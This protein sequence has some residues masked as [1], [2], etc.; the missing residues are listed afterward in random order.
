M[1]R[2]LLAGTAT[3]GGLLL[4][5][6]SS[7]GDPGALRAWR[8]A[9]PVLSVF[10]AR[11][12]PAASRSVEEPQQAVAVAAALQ[13][14][15][16]ALQ[17]DIRRLQ[18]Q[19]AD[20]MQ[21]VAGLQA[22]ADQAKRE[23]EQARVNQAAAGQAAPIGLGQAQDVPGDAERT[24]GPTATV[25]RDADQSDAS[26][27]PPAKRPADVDRQTASRRFE[28]AQPARSAEPP[29]Q[30]EVQDP[31]PVVAPVPVG[32]APHG[33]APPP[34][35]RADV[36]QRHAAR[37]AA[38][39]IRDRSAAAAASAAANGALQDSV[40]S[41]S[42]AFA[43]N[44]GQTQPGLDRLSRPPETPSS[45]EPPTAAALAT[46]PPVPAGF[47][48]PRRVTPRDRLAKARSAIAAGR[49]A[50]A[51]QLL[52]EAQLQLVFRP[53]TAGG[54][55]PSTGSRSAGQVADAL[56]MLGSGD[57]GRA[58]QIIDQALTEAR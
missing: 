46:D 29:R 39:S 44:A 12:E 22:R 50:E 55:E 18:A 15:R 38:A 30:A 13:R 27:D 36:R 24:P 53:S 31:Q 14:Q 5:L 4:L 52:E 57:A 33:P 51:Q 9:I 17:D 56:T 26:Q 42:G 16:D 25:Q 49:I 11:P 32:V 3:V 48:E 47:G 40:H 43:T 21:E 7:F 41:G 6:I 37:R 19:V 58:V 23:L 28:S 2:F 45:G 54:G 1:V 35:A 8:G 20:A 34:G 10:Q